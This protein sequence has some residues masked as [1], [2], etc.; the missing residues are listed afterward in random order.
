M[1]HNVGMTDMT[2]RHLGNSGLTVST[3][4]I[5]CN[6]FGLRIDEDATRLV[7][8]A[9]IDSG[10]TLFDTSDS[11]G[12]SEL[13]LGRALGTR[14]ADV[15]LA[16]KFGSD[17]RGAN[18]PDWNARGSR[19]YIRRAVERSLT[20]L[21]T[22]W[23]DLYQIH[24]PDPGT[25]IEETLGALSDLVHE[26]LVRYIGCSN[27]AAWQVADADWIS[28]TNGFERFISA[29]NHYSLV[30]RGVEA[31]LVPA[32]DRFGLGLLPYFPLASGLL[33]GKYRRGDAPPEGGRIAAWGMTTLLSD[34]NFDIVER[35]EAFAAERSITLLD[36]AMGGLAAQPTVASVIA[37]ATSVAQV[38][39]NATAGVWTPTAEDRVALRGLLAPG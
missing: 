16:T 14:R 37:G 15:I 10:I 33:T 21:N 35:L 24:M 38:Q 3:V 28:Q 39:A 17:L 8:D 22:D 1:G 5:G 27:F 7:V 30:E 18:G 12:D 31:E 34:A 36:V 4:G 13:F 9:A 29:Q 25:P 32:C 19:R 26:G 6:N 2:Y 11:Y 23:I 20:R